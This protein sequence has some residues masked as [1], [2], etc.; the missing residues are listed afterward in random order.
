MKTYLYILL[1]GF[2]CASCNSTRKTTAVEHPAKKSASSDPKFLESITIKSGSRAGSGVHKPLLIK[3]NNNAPGVPVF[4]IEKCSDL[5]FKYGI[6]LNADVETITNDKM[7][8]FLEEWYGIPY[9]FGG[10][11]KGGIDCSAF[12]A[13]MMDSVYAIDL[14]RTC[15][16]QYAGGMKIRKD[17]LIQGDL[18]FF[19]TVGA[20]SHVGVFLGN[21]KFVHASTSNGVMISDLDELYFKKRY[22]GGVRVR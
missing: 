2:L 13:L 7:I 14:P 19:N 8:S 9:K 6:L 21:N 3:G 11:G 22:V 5:Q 20:I 16:D 4:N 1:A 15:R 10:E 18:V 17:Q 12:C